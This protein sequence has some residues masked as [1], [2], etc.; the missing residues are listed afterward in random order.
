MVRRYCAARQRQGFAEHR[1]IAKLIGQDQHQ[2]RVKICALVFR[3]ATMRTRNGAI[4]RIGVGETCLGVQPCHAAPAFLSPGFST[5]S[6][7]NE[8]EKRD[9]PRRWQEFI[10]NM[11][12]PNGFEPSAF[13]FGGQNLPFAAVC[14]GFLSCHNM[15]FFLYFYIARDCFRLH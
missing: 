13:A 1:H 11:A 8:R 7:F 9:D 4:G 12:D 6:P 14:A 5:V 10:E 2:G 3:E 15:L